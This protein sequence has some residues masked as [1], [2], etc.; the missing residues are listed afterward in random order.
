MTRLIHTTTGCRVWR[1]QISLPLIECLVDG[2]KYCRPGDLSPTG[3]E[4]LPRI[5]QASAPRPDW[6]NWRGFSSATG[7]RSSG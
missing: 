1:L 5:P 3:E 4:P 6:K 7:T 2:V